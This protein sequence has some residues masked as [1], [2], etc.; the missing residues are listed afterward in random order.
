MVNSGNTSMSAVMLS[1]ITLTG[2]SHMVGDSENNPFPGIFNGNG[3]TLTVDFKDTNKAYLAPFRYINAATIRN[4][5][6]AGSIDGKQ[7]PAGLAGRGFV[8]SENLIENCRVSATVY[9]S[10]VNPH[11]G[12]FIGHNGSAATT[13]NNCL[14]DGKIIARETNSDSYAAPFIGWED[15][16]THN[17]VT[18]CLEDGLYDNFY[19]TAPNYHYTDMAAARLTAIPT[20]TRT[21]IRA[22]ADSQASTVAKTCRTNNWPTVWAARAGKPWTAK[23][24]RR[25]RTL[26]ARTRASTYGTTMRS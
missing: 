18:N 10:A 26:V 13:L 5:H 16:G 4:L 1:D 25:C 3:H 19:H 22:K 12:G 15:G 21:T 23:C 24:C 11:A 7:H 2:T 9:S 20:S 17:A 14:F 6:V 8:K